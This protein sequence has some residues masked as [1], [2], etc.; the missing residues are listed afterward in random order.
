[1]I[2]NNRATTRVAPTRVGDIV[3]AFQSIVTVNYIRAVKNFG[4]QSFDKK[5]WQRNYYEH[6]IRDI[7]EYSHIAEYIKNNPKKWNNE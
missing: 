5:L 1:M 6:I 7:N 2:T 4:W 3:G